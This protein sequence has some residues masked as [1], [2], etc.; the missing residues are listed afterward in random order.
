MNKLSKVAV[1]VLVVLGT[2]APQA[3]A[4]ATHGP[5]FDAGR[6]PRFSTMTYTVCFDGG[7]LAMIQVS[8]DGDTDLDL[9]VF[10]SNGRLVASDNDWTDQCIVAFVPTRTQY[11]TIQI[12]NHGPVFNNFT[13]TTN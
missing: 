6:V 12:V 3:D 5:G 9:R 11:F 2:L 10:D 4:G 7:E 1:C 8:G 13:L